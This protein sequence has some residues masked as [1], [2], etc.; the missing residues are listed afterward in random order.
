MAVFSKPP[1]PTTKPP[2]PTQFEAW[3]LRRAKGGGWHLVTVLASEKDVVDETTN[4]LMTAQIGRIVAKL[5][6]LDR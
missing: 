3:T 1:P 4:D 2:P 6:R 5:G